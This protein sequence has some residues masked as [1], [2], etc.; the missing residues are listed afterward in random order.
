MAIISMIDCSLLSLLWLSSPSLPVGAFAFSQGLEQLIDGGHLNGA[1]DFEEYLADELKLSLAYWD[2]PLLKRMYEA[3]IAQ[4]QPRLLKL[5]TLF[6]AGRETKELYEEERLI[7]SALMTLMRKLEVL[8]PEFASLQVGQT[9]AWALFAAL[10]PQSMGSTKPECQSL[11]ESYAFALMQG[12]IVCACKI[13]PLGQSTGQAVLLRLIPVIKEAC[14][15]AMKLEDQDL[16]TALPLT[17][18]GSALHE[19]QYSR[20]FRS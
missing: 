8:P 7:G 20:L 4:D 5:D 17:M 3:V 6:Q 11:L 14:Q 15:T 12:A 16:G 9:P 13:M 19:R 10:V 18:I 1:Q 2:L